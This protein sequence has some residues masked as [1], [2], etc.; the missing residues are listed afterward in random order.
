[1]GGNNVYFVKSYEELKQIMNMKN[2]EVVDIAILNEGRNAMVMARPIKSIPLAHPNTSIVV[3]IVR[4]LRLDIS[5]QKTK[6]VHASFWVYY[7]AGQTHSDSSF[8]LGWAMRRRAALLVRTEI[9][10][11]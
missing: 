8:G 7:G 9:A 4:I 11:F 1:M 2:Q 5:P 6:T 10:T 3:G